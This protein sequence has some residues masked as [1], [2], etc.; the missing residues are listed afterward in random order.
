M[1]SIQPD[2]L[3]RALRYEP[4][5]ASDRM[6]CRF[7][8]ESFSEENAFVL[9]AAS[10]CL[11]AV[12]EGHCFFDL[13][14]PELP[15]LLCETLGDAWPT[16]AE[17]VSI[18]ESSHSIGRP[19]DDNPLILDGESA[20]YIHRYF[21]YE[22]ELANKVSTKASQLVPTSLACSNSSPISESMQAEAV[23]K[24]LKNRFYLISGGPGTG[25]TTT[26][27]A[28]LVECIQGLDLSNPLRIAVAA[29][30][31]KA[32]ARVSNSIRDGLTRFDLEGSVEKK[33][34]SIPCLTIHRLLE[35]I[36]GKTSFRRNQNRPLEYD[37]LIVDE[38]SMIDLPLMR[39]LMDA[40]PEDSSILLLGDD[41]QLSSVEVGSVFGDLVRSTRNRQSPLFGKSTHLTKTF[42]FTP[43]SSIFR[44]CQA[45][46][47]GHSENFRAILEGKQNDL[48]FQ[49][50]KKTANPSLASVLNLAEEAFRH[51]AQSENL[52]E[53]FGQL[54]QFIVLAPLN[55]GPFGANTINRLTEEK[56]RRQLGLA[57]VEFYSGQ[58]LLVLEN[59]YD[60]GLFTG[61]VGIV[62][63]D[64]SG[65]LFAWFNDSEGAYQKIR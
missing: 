51:R 61:D 14:S 1:N 32:A 30:T 58:P 35:A 55:H 25:K 34:L 15:E 28:Y 57:S 8:K 60:L 27:L 50:L 38:S 43:N 10:L 39:K 46:N 54:S 49:T 2:Q 65:E 31:G 23:E 41:N 20:L 42:R 33:I 56:I 13:K 6:F 59:N 45:C 11:S 48:N 63:P 62:W 16:V 53:A 64:E 37:I 4:F 44:L 26:V 21:T 5:A 19:S 47:D 3:E 36:P 24:A 7:L 22:T 52:A 40:V 17:W 9:A 29:P 12:R 18:A